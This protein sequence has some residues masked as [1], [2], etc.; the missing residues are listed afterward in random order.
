MVVLGDR[1]VPISEKDTEAPRD[2]KTDPMSQSR[3]LATPGLAEQLSRAPLPKHLESRKC[4]VV[5]HS[6]GSL[7]WLSSPHPQ[8]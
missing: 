3:N 4:S 2:W 6:Q 5:A 1:A 7:S 8:F